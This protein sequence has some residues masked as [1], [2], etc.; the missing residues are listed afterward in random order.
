[1]KIL[2][3]LLVGIALFA[4]VSTASAQE[5][6]KLTPSERAERHTA[7]MT[8]VLGLTADQRAKVA[9]LNLGVAMKNEAIRNDANMTPEQK[10]EAIKGNHEGRKAQ[11][12]LI[13]TE[14]QFKKLEQHEA[15]MKAK[16]D[17]KKAEMK[18][19]KQ[20]VKPASEE[21]EEL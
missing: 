20:K 13:L 11:L 10:K 6:K 2:N 19:K 14:E 5:K 4:G 9:E 12:K 21:L 18:K 15:E 8:E 1:M 7:K 3:V 17:A 16:R